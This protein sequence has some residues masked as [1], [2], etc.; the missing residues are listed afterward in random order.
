MINLAPV[1]CCTENKSAVLSL[2]REQQLRWRERPS[3]AALRTVMAARMTILLYVTRNS[4]EV[5][6]AVSKLLVRPAQSLSPRR[7][8][9]QSLSLAAGNRRDRRETTRALCFC[10]AKRSAEN[11]SDRPI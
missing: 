2:S 9:R 6:R 7:A 4:Q 5:C 8:Q 1:C 11:Y 3:A 10:T